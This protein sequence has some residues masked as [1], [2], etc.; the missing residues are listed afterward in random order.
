MPHRTRFL[1]AS[2]WKFSEYHQNFDIRALISVSQIF[3]WWLPSSCNAR[4]EFHTASFLAEPQRYI[5]LTLRYSELNW[6]K[7]AAKFHVLYHN[8]LSATDLHL[9]Q[10]PQEEFNAI[11]RWSTLPSRHE[12]LIRL[13]NK[14]LWLKEL[15]KVSARRVFKLPSRRYSD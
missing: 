6:S 4:L 10:A 13:P 14:F 3:L 11:C 15:R 7:L 12:P 1:L 8:Q 9:L 2:P 5:L